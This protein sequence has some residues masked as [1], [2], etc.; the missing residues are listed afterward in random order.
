[1][2]LKELSKVVLDNA[3]PPPVGLGAAAGSA[4]QGPVPAPAPPPAL[5]IRRRKLRGHEGK[6]EEAA[7]GARVHCVYTHYWTPESERRCRAFPA[8]FLDG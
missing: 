8:E 7:S 2:D 4:T 3:S 5:R 1:M 6:E